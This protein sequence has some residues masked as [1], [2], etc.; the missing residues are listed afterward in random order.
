M[1]QRVVAGIGNIYRAEILFLTGLHPLRPSSSLSVPELERLWAVMK[2]LLQRGVREERIW[3]IEPEERPL[4]ERGRRFYVYQQETC[5]RCGSRIATLTLTG[6]TI[7]ACAR[8]Q[9][10]AGA[11]RDRK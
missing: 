8:C 10:S 1:D 7:F 6:R 3:T 4:T 11:R 5:L 9:R 2:R